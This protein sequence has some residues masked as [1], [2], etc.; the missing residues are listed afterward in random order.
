MQDQINKKSKKQGR[1]KESKMTSIN[2]MKFNDKQ[3]VLICDEARGWNPEGM[4]LHTSDKIKPIIIPE[5]TKDTGLVA[6]YGNTGTS[7]IGDELKFT[8]KQSITRKYEEERTKRL[9]LPKA[10]LTIEEIALMTYDIQIN[11]KREHLDETLLG[12]YGF[13]AKEFISGSYSKNGQNIEIKSD[14]IINTVSDDLIW[15]GRKGEPTS[16]FLNAGIIAGYEPKEGFRI[17]HLSLIDF[18]CEPVQELFLGDGSGRDMTT[19]VFTEHSNKKTIPEKR[20]NIDVTEGLFICIKAVNAAVRHDLGVEG[21]LSLMYIDGNQEDNLKKYKEI[22]DKRMKLLAE[23][24]EA[25][26]YDLVSRDLCY[27]AIERVILEDKSFDCTYDEVKGKIKDFRKF[28][29]FL[30]GYK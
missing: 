2:A 27:L 20:G 6:Y 7:S 21:Q 29:R 11:M 23:L 14:E 30:R 26:Y 12:R 15:N 1:V 4:K 19:V 3:G 28:S 22:S 25:N 9:S 10:F 18:S 13:S 24:V 8:I 5:I 16:I 17:F